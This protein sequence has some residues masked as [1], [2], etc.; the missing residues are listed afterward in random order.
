MPLDELNVAL[1]GVNG[2]LLDNRHSCIKNEMLRMSK[3][4]YQVHDG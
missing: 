2:M 1:I 4:N 3:T